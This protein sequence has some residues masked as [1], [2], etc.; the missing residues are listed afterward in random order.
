MTCQIER[1]PSSDTK[2]EPSPAS[3]T[4]T[5]RPHTLPSPMVNPVRK[6]SYSPVAC[7]FFMGSEVRVYKD[8]GGDDLGL[9]LGV[10]A[11]VTRILMAAHVPPRPTVEST[12][13]HVG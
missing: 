7:P 10:F 8:V 1:V 2:R 6:S 9:Q 11:H 12:L 13:L 3:A 4:P 5:G